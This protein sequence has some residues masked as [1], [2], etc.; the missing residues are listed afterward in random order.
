LKNAA[1]Q[2]GPNGL[3]TQQAEFNAA[4]F[5]ISLMI[6]FIA[7]VLAGIAIGLDNLTQIDPSDMKVLLGIA[8]A[9]YA[10]ADFIEN[11]FS[12]LVPNVGAS[13]SAPRSG[14][15]SGGIA[16]LV[17]L[18]PPLGAGTPVLP[19]EIVGLKAALRVTAPKLDA[20]IWTPA[21]SAAFTKHGITTHRRMAAALGQFL[22]E[23]GAAFQQRVENLNY[24]H[25]ERIA[26][27]FRHEIPTPADAERF[28]AQPEALGNFVYANRNGN[29]DEGSGDGYRFRGRGLIQ[30]TGRT[31]YASFAATVGQSPE[32]ISSYCETP[33]GAASSGCWFLSSHGCPALAD[34]WEIA[35]ITR[36]VNGSAM[37]G[38]AQRLA[39][40]EAALKALGG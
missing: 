8:A 38:A 16:D 21:L 7:G 3:P 5:A 11:T 19:G 33:E 40:S 18:A 6:G 14:S 29:G 12:R 25:A 39:Y 20:E 13:P 1:T 34:A 22:V 15:G 35:Q 36:L 31:A 24:S 10:G 2:S 9:G 28:V 4:Y 30:L 26:E 37:Q 17:Q 23:A 32:T 27:V